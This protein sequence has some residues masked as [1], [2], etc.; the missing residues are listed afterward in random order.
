MSILNIISSI[1]LLLLFYGCSQD[2]P[3]EPVENGYEKG[4]VTDIGNNIYETVKIGELWW[5][6]E[7]LRVTRYRN[8]DE[9]PTGLDNGV[10]GDTTSGAFAVYPHG[11]VDH[12]DSDEEMLEAYGA[13]YNWHAV[14][15]ERGLCPEGWRVPA[16]V[17]WKLLEMYLGVSQQAVEKTGWRENDE[18]GKL[19]STRTIPLIHPTWES[20]NLGATN[21]TGWS[22]L[23]GGYRDYSG[24]FGYLGTFGRWWSSSEHVPG[25]DYVV[26]R[27]LGSNYS[28]ISR[29]V[30]LKQHG[31]SVRCVRV[32]E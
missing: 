23:P 17:E 8:G 9:M 15:D 19:K 29:F 2:N 11:L 1:T 26:F 10:W 22:G 14:A 24:E 28:G 7:N 32:D 16:D 3:I 25:G 21:E 6:A 27:S 5:M 4:M 20:P 12:I 13:L 31:F 18:G 30:A